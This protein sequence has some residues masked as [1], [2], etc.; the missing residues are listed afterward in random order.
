MSGL[1]PTC[2]GG[3]ETGGCDPSLVSWLSHGLFPSRMVASQKRAS[4]SPNTSAL[5]S[6]PPCGIFRR[7]VLQQPVQV[8]NSRHGACRRAYTRCHRLPA[9]GLEAS[10]QNPCPGK[11]LNHQFE[12][13]IVLLG[14]KSGALV[15]YWRGPP[16]SVGYH[17]ALLLHDSF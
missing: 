17:L 12:Q 15:P 11:T 8:L 16:P 7:S 6:M 13:G 9:L 5:F 1:N 2:L 3:C 4:L 14:G 10:Y